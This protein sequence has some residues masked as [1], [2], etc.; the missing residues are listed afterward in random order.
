ASGIAVASGS[1]VMIIAP[2]GLYKSMDGGESWN[3]IGLGLPD[4]HI[5][6]AIDP[7]NPNT[8]YAGTDYGLFKST[9]AGAG[10][11]PVNSGLPL[12]E[13]GPPPFPTGSTSFH[14]DS[15]IVD[16]QQPD[17][18]YALISNSFGSTVFKTTNGG[19][20]WSE[21]NSGLPKRTFIRSLQIDLQ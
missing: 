8:L 9:D 3:R 7:Q 17:T 5:E 15:V 13:I 1:G 19:A 6:L 4:S 16:P 14:A 11:S 21:A 18:V 20:S 10:W 12:F 2:G